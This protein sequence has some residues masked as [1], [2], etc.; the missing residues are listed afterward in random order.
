MGHMRKNKITLLLVALLLLITQGCTTFSY[1]DKALK[2]ELPSKFEMSWTPVFKGIEIMSLDLPHGPILIH[3]VKINTKEKGIA[4]F[5][6]PPNGEKPFD[7]EGQKTSAFLTKYNLQIA[8]NGTPYKKH[9]GLFKWYYEVIGLSV[10]QGTRYSQGIESWGYLG[11]TA[12]KKLFI[13]KGKAIEEDL[14]FALGGFLPI[15]WKG[16][17]VGIDEERN[18][19]TALGLNEQGD[20]LYIV[21]VEGRKRNSIGLK[22]SEVGQILLAMGVWD[23]INLDG[24]SSSTLVI[25]SPQG[26]LI[27][28]PRK[29]RAVA[30]H[31]GI[32]ADKLESSE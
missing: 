21:L 13:N 29:E 9:L 4:F 27:Y 6:T 26:P 24:G 30:N 1:R 22:S 19:R 7:H 10:S 23:A 16:N 25:E 5:V 2:G 3:I 18:P 8:V 20:L 12:D 11:I 28:G 31:L 14:Q 32:Y 15:L 17:N